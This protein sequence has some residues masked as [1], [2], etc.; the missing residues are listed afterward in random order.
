VTFASLRL[1]LDV[2]AVD[3]IRM[4]GRL[5]DRPVLLTHGTKDPYNPPA[6]SADRNF[7]AAQDADVPVELR[8]C[9]GAGHAQV[10]VKCPREWREWVTTFLDPASPG[11][12][13]ERWCRSRESNP[14]EVALHGV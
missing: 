10:V 11:F 7:K 5:G 6:Q 3:P 1:G 14:D 8:Y 12:V 9:E 13:R 2:S 4:I